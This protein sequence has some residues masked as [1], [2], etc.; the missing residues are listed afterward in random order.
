MALACDV[1]IAVPE[2]KFFY[3]VM[4]LGFLPQP[5]DPGRLADLIGSARA[6]M[7]LMAGAKI[8]AEEAR[9]WGLIDRIV[10]PD[11]LMEEARALATDTLAAKPGHAAGI[12]AMFAGG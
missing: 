1:R 9:A 3:P 2:A 6:K 12:K 11:A 4:R 8:G 10:A 5:S 7:I